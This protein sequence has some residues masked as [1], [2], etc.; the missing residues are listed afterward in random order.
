M[1]VNIVSVNSPA[2]ANAN[3]Y[4]ACS[5][6]FPEPFAFFGVFHTSPLQA[7][8][9]S[10]RVRTR[11]DVF[12]RGKLAPRVEQVLE[13]PKMDAIPRGSRRGQPLVVGAEKIYKQSRRIVMEYQN[14]RDALELRESWMISEVTKFKYGDEEKL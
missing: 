14:F 12:F 2:P 8:A 4:W 9:S 3:Y 1:H 11:Q 6:I 13:T 5:Y 7:V 10:G